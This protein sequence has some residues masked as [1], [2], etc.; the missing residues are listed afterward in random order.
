MGTP[1]ED[2]TGLKICEGC[3]IVNHIVR[4]FKET[5]DGSV[6][7]IE[8]DTDDNEYFDEPWSTEDY[9]DYLG[10]DEDSGVSAADWIEAFEP[11]Y[12]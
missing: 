7:E 3:V 5:E 1:C 2:G 8:D 10:W 9:A 4:S 12:D 11:D 6:N